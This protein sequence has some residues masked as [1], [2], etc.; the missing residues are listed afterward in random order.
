M[1]DKEIN[2]IPHTVQGKHDI[3]N[4]LAK[5]LLDRIKP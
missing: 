5:F 4:H 2:K 3:I 1:N